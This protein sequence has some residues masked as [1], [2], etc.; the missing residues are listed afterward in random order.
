MPETPIPS[1]PPAT[2]GMPVVKKS[3]QSDSNI[4]RYGAVYERCLEAAN[5]IARGNLRFT[6]ARVEKLAEI[7]FNRFF[8]DQIKILDQSQKQR[9]KEKEQGALETL[10][11]QIGNR[12]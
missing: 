2:T 6:D 8:D 5:K 11:R 3:D 10:M 1:A 12:I 7:F 4:K 9:N